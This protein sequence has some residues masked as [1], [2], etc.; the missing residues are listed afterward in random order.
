MS[1]LIWSVHSKSTISSGV[2][3][4]YADIPPLHI[5]VTSNNASR[6]IES[7]RKLFAFTF[8]TASQPSMPDPGCIRSSCTQLLAMDIEILLTHYSSPLRLADVNV[9][10]RT[11]Q[12]KNIQQP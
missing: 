6:R 9:R 8:L 3:T 2:S 11:K 1:G 7:V 4:E 5:S 12:P 10:E